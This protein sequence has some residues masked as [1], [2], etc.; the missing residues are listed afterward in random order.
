MITSV[1]AMNI[2][3]LG[4]DILGPV[5]APRGTLQRRLLVARSAIAYFGTVATLVQIVVWLMIA[6]FSGALDSPWW[7]WTAVP[8]LAAVGALSIA[9]RWHSWFTEELS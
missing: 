9:A 8:A 4:Q 3:Q 6:A 1:V 7:L 5:R 2:T